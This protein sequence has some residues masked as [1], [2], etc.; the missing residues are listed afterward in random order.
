[1]QDNHIN[2]AFNQLPLVAFSL[3]RQAPVKGARRGA[4][5]AK[6]AFTCP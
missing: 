5:C 1:M 4:L 3:D 6:R 2:I